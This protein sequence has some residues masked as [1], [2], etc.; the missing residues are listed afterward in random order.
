[1]NKYMTRP[2]QRRAFK[3]SVRF[4]KE[5]SRD[6]LAMDVT[7]A[8]RGRKRLACRMFGISGKRYRDLQRKDWRKMSE[9][10]SNG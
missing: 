7:N 5:P 6:G 10:V 8:D 2:E 1:M 4:R 3:L 9:A